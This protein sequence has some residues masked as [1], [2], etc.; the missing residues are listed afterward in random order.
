M[1]TSSLLNA[2]QAI[3]QFQQ[4]FKDNEKAGA[5]IAL[6]DVEGNSRILQNI[7]AQGRRQEK[8]VYVFS[9]D[10]TGEKVSHVNYVS[11]SF[12]AKGA[13]ARTWASS[14]TDII[15]GRSGGKEDSAQ[16]VGTNG[17]RVQEALDKAEKYLLGL[18]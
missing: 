2:L 17:S 3:E 16:G 15:G 8:A 12:K 6:L 7:V 10:E 18:V 9:V 4:Y 14:V 11:P 1:N 13:D 5:Y